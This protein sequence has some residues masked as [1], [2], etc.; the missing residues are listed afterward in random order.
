M[1][2]SLLGSPSD[3]LQRYAFLSYVTIISV[4]IIVLFAHVYMYQW[5][6]VGTVFSPARGWA[7]WF[8]HSATCCRSGWSA[9]SPPSPL[10]APSSYVQP[11]HNVFHEADDRC[12]GCFDMHWWDT[13]VRDVSRF[14]AEDERAT[15]SHPI[16]I[17]NDGRREKD[18]AFRD[19]GSGKCSWTRIHT[20]L[21]QWWSP[22]HR[23]TPYLG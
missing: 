19:S 4:I 20:S 17:E 6:A 14:A 21:T 8:A 22:P 13:I 7:W 1:P 2:K 15:H 10:P 16:I 5:V 11:V 3:L 9:L 23:Q 18:V 12:F